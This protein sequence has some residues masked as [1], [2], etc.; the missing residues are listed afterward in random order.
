MLE[1][2]SLDIQDETKESVVPPT[3]LRH[4]G[5]YAVDID[6]MVDFYRT[7]LGLVVS[8]EGTASFGS[9]LVFMTSGSGEHHEFVI[10]EGRPEESGFNPIAQLSF[11]VRSLKD[12]KEFRRVLEL[13]GVEKIDSANHGNAWSL[14]LRDPDG[15]LV[16]LYVDT[17]FHTPQPCRGPLDLTAT[18]EE[19]LASTEEF[20]RSRPGFATRPAWEQQ[21]DERVAKARQGGIEGI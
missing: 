16:E 3:S 11:K 15:N 8:D 13:N 4:T 1:K 5:V 9:R 18:D 2:T 21:I 19:I 12:L 10:V 17:P 7:C 14:Y 6:R 20:C